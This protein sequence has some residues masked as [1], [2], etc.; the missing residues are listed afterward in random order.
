MKQRI[1]STL[2]LASLACNVH[3]TTTTPAQD[4]QDGVIILNIDN[5][6][7]FYKNGA[8]AVTNADKQL[9][10]AQINFINKGR[11]YGFRIGNTQDWHTADNIS[12]ASNPLWQSQGKKA[13]D[14]V[15][16]PNG[17]AQT[18]WPD[19][20]VQGTYGAQFIDGL[21]QEGDLVQQKGQDPKVD[22]YSGFDD[23]AGDDTGLDA[24]LRAEK[25]KIIIAL[26]L[27]TDYCVN[28]TMKGGL[29]RDYATHFLLNLSRGITR[30]GSIA[31]MLDLQKLAQDKKQTFTVNYLTDANDGMQEEEVQAF[32]K[33]GVTVQRSTVDAFLQKFAPRS[34]AQSVRSVAPELLNKTTNTSVPTLIIAQ[35]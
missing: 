15:T 24:K 8:L 28:F 1:F 4:A 2:A 18:L 34:E 17:Q 22:S 10:Q 27:A 3:A 13:F 7:D 11:K 31:A 25:I 29:N 32:E 23:N 26:G 9:A 19:H 30:E 12:F 33:A 35:Q 16:T 6:N 20:C 21:Y 14:Q 5:Q